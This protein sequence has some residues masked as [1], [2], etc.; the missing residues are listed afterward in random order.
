MTTSKTMSLRVHSKWRNTRILCSCH[1]CQGR[2]RIRPITRRLRNNWRISQQIQ[3]T[4]SSKNLFSSKAS[5]T[6]VTTKVIT[7][8]G[9]TLKIKFSWFWSTSLGSKKRRGSMS[10]SSRWRFRKSWG[11]EKKRLEI[12][13]WINGRGSSASTPRSKLSK[14][15]SSNLIKNHASLRLDQNSANWSIR[16]RKNGE[17]PENGRIS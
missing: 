8:Q 12:L 17:K 9:S 6:W 16:F 15:N 14:E 7:S 2:C 10:S 13:R 5:M 11:K 3:L 1:R 4:S